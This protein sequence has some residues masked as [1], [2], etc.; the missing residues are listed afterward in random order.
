MLSR[1]EAQ[2]KFGPG[3]TPLIAQIYAVAEQAGASIVDIQRRGG[4]LW[5]HTEALAVEAVEYLLVR[6]LEGRSAATCEGCGGLGMRVTSGREA[7]ILCAL[8]A[9]PWLEDP[10][11][12][13]HRI[14]EGW[15][16][17]DDRSDDERDGIDDREDWQR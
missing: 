9:Y 12:A 3:F 2:E 17:D 16:S 11:R 10:T 1:E 6:V 14:V 7:R 8:H 4:A 15:K 13:W 5:V